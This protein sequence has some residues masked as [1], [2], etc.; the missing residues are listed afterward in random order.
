MTAREFAEFRRNAIRSYAAAN[1]ETGD[2][3]REHAEDRA[4]IDTDRLLPQ[5]LDTPGMLL[6]VAEVGAH[7]VGTVWIAVED[8]NGQGAW[9]YDIEI[10]ASHRGRGLGRALLMAAEEV[11]AVNGA[12][13]IGLNVFADNAAARGLYESSGYEVT[14]LHMRKALGSD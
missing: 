1:V 7:P 13:S 11:V 2:W 3:A 8:P 9:I 10:A 12:S 6:L 5:G 4:A 14:S